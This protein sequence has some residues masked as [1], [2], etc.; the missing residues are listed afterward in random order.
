MDN[1]RALQMGPDYSFLRDVLTLQYLSHF[2]CDT[3]SVDVFQLMEIS[4]ALL[5]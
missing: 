2:S 4:K 1:V 5:L 3:Y